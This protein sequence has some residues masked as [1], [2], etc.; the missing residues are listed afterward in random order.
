M[1]GERTA[2]GYTSVWIA[3]AGNCWVVGLGSRLF[4]H[5]VMRATDPSPPT[6]SDGLRYFVSFRSASTP[7]PHTLAMQIHQFSYCVIPLRLNLKSLVAV[8]GA[9]KHG[10]LELRDVYA[11][12]SLSQPSVGV[13]HLLHVRS[14]GSHSGHSRGD[15]AGTSGSALPQKRRLGDMSGAQTATANEVTPAAS[16]G[17]EAEPLPSA[18][19]DSTLRSASAHSQPPHSQLLLLERLALEVDPVGHTETAPPCHAVPH[20]ILI[21][22]LGAGGQSPPHSRGVYGDCVRR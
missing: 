8:Y 2:Q 20:P 6:F 1:I 17:T 11:G 4:E 21:S 12:K 13:R 16:D 3:T 18:L 15:G 22:C 7:T 10:A 14:T 9:G 5:E 19:L